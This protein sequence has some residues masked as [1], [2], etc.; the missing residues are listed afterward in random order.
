MDTIQE[1]EAYTVHELT[2]ERCGMPIC[3][4]LY[5]Y[6]PKGGR[7]SWPTAI[8]GHGF[9]GVNRQKAAAELSAFVQRVCGEK[10]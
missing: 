9:W 10:S 3:G 8:M 2:F 6:L 4:N 7:K 5:L 1:T